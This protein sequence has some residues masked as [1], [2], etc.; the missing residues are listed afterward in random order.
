MVVKKA[1]YNN[2]YSKIGQKDQFFNTKDKLH[3]PD[4]GLWSWAGYDAT[5]KFCNDGLFLVVDT[6]TKFVQT[7]TLQDEIDDLTYEGWSKEDIEQE[8]LA[9]EGEKRVVVLTSYNPKT[10]QI[11]GLSFK[12]TP[13]NT[14]FEWKRATRDRQNP[15]VI[16]SEKVMKTSI[17][18]YLDIVHGIKLTAQ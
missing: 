11:D 4:M 3:I 5:P 6:C 15:D 17:A 9:K 13:K 2:S 7:R 8:F 10:Y 18:E 14:V 16:V 12:I 1:L